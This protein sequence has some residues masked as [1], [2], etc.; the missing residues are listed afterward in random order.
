[1]TLKDAWKDNDLEKAKVSEEDKE[2]Y[3]KRLGTSFWKDKP[4]GRTLSLRNKTGKIGVTVLGGAASTFIPGPVGD[5]INKG[6]ETLIATQTT[7]GMDFV[8]DMSVLQMIIAALAVLLPI[9]LKWKFPA[10]KEKAA[11][12]VINERLDNVADEAIKAV[13]KDSEDGKKISRNE[14]KSIIA[15]GLQKEE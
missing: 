10:L 15:S 3:E 5:W 8:T 11:W 9:I 4:L 12:S 2:A 14:W 1:M 7:V 13:D 6:F